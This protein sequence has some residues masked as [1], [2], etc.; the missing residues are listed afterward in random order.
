MVKTVWRMAR[1]TSTST[2]AHHGVSKQAAT[3]TVASAKRR[4][5]T[6]IVAVFI[7]GSGSSVAWLFFGYR[8][9]AGI[10]AYLSMA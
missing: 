7:G 6:T 1:M 3:A 5:E 4:E 8:G 2:R 9:V 10:V